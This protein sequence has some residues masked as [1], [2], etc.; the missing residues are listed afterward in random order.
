MKR[1]STQRVNGEDPVSIPVTRRAQVGLCPHCS[2]PH[3]V[4]IDE[5]GD[6]VAML[7]PEQPAEFVEELLAV[8]RRV[9]ERDRA[10]PVQ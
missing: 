4:L 2:S 5:D 7:V 6:P 8:L 9:A 10:G 3:I 1:P